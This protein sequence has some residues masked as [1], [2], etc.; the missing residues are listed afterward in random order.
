MSVERP[1]RSEDV[2]SFWLRRGHLSLNIQPNFYS[3]QLGSEISKEISLYLNQEFFFLQTALHRIIELTSPKCIDNLNTSINRKIEYLVLAK[4]VGFDVPS[5]SIVQSKTALNRFFIE[6]NG[7]V[8]AKAINENIMFDIKNGDGVVCPTVVIT[9]TDVEKSSDKFFPTL[10]QQKVQKKID[11]RVFYFLGKVYSTAI[12]TPE[13][14]KSEIDYRVVDRIGENLTRIVP[15]KLSESDVEKVER[16]MK[17][18]GRESGSL[19]FVLSFD[20]KMY[21]LEL[22]PVGQF[23]FISDACNFYIEKE[24]AKKL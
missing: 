3:S 15:Y 20:N 8:V 14:H 10:L 21:F 17:L 2:T 13:K 1:V 9:D 6:N 4:N 11:I 7:M 23:G 24:I 18:V 16:F 5:T 12:F 22:N 19:D